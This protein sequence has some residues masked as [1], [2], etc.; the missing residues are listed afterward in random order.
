[1]KSEVLFTPAALF[2]FL[3]QIEELKSYAVSVAD[4]PGGSIQISIGDSIYNV[5]GQDAVEVPVNP[6][7]VVEVREAAEDAYDE[8]GS[9][10]NNTANLEPVTSGVLKQIVKTLLIGGLVRL[11]DRILHK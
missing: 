6:N 3:T 2:D 9:N 10:V 1:M 11:T 7:T 4:T 5:T 8:L